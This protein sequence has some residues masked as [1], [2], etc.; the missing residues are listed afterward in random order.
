MDYLNFLYFLFFS[1]NEIEIIVTER[2]DSLL[3]QQPNTPVEIDILPDDLMYIIYTSGSTGK[4]KGV[5]NQHSGLVNRLLWAKQYF[6]IQPDDVFLQK[7]TFCFDVSVWEFFLPLIVGAELVIASPQGHKDSD[8]L[9][10]I[11]DAKK[12]TIVHFVPPMLE[13]FLLDTNRE[14]CPSLQRVV[15]SGE[16]L[17][18]HHIGAFQKQL[19]HV[20]LCNLYGPTEAAIDVTAWKIPN[21]FNINEEV[22][23]GQPVANTKILILNS[24]DQQCPIG[25]VGELHIAGIQVARGYWKREDLNSEK[26]IE[27][28]QFSDY[29]KIYKTG[30][31]AQWTENGNIKFLGRIDSQVKVRGFRIE[32]E[33]IEFVL[34]EVEAIQQ[35]IVLAIPDA[36]GNNVLVAYFVASKPIEENILVKYMSEKLPEYMIPTHFVSLEKIPV[37]LNGKIDRSALPFPE[38]NKKQIATQIEPQTEFEEIVQEVWS[39]VLQINPIGLHDNFAELGGDSLNGIRVMSRLSA[40]FELELPVNL[41]FQ[42]PTIAQ[43]ANHI[44]VIITNILQE[45]ENNPS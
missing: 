34:G 42:K 33:E 39:E 12:V 9:R 30:D 41:I 38:K 31:L 16:S 32:L 13:V 40:A 24:L 14:H 26:F 10:Q 20:T 7:T 35:V 45:L 3:S 18:S 11:I 22:P 1:N 37:T 36:F 44:E 27:L 25:G 8:Y 5:M 15:C 29:G 21:S 43:L 2:F 19:P 4:P 17:K 6:D 28:P 23:I